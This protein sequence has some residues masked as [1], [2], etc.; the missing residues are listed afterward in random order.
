MLLSPTKNIPIYDIKEGH[1]HI[2]SNSLFTHNL[3]F[4]TT[5]YASENMSLNIQSIKKPSLHLS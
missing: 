2:L 4:D 3:A 1:N 5:T